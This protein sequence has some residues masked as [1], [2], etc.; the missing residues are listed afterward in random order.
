[1]EMKNSLLEMMLKHQVEA[2]HNKEIVNLYYLVRINWTKENGSCLNSGDY[3]AHWNKREDH[4]AA[5]LCQYFKK[6]GYCEGCDAL[7]YDLS[8]IGDQN[9]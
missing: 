7:N 3:K 5:M 1:M 2:E 4:A 8:Q 6:N 9:E